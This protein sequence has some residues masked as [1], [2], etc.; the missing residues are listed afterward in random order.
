MRSLLRGAAKK[1]VYSRGVEWA[2]RRSFL[3]GVR[4]LT[5]HRFSPNE[6][7]TLEAHC[8]HF[9]K[10]YHPLALGDYVDALYGRKL[11]PANGLVVTV[12]D[13]YHDVLTVAAP[14]FERYRIPV[15]VHLV[16]GFVDRQCWLWWDVLTYA[17]SHSKRTEAIIELPD[18]PRATVALGAPERRRTLAAKCVVA[19]AGT[20]GATQEVWVADL[21][22]QL[23]VRV[24]AEP[25]EE[26]S[27][28]TWEQVRRMTAMG[29][30][31]GAHTVNHRILGA[32]ESREEKCLEI[33]D[34]RRRIEEQLQMPVEHF[35]YPN[36]GIGDFD[37]IDLALLKQAGYRSAVTTL[38]GIGDG[39]SE[40]PFQLPRIGID[41]TQGSGSLFRLN[42]AGLWRFRSG[43]GWRG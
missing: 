9:R 28:L 26:F 13:G 41:F 12:D 6:L 16:S 30:S 18:S 25:V 1:I 5:Y 31:F 42:L 3:G 39:R 15:M 14:V 2:I 8:R 43:T 40:D 38:K 27:A 20:D 17:F 22:K 37:R 34:S 33:V 29:F 23:D 36:G 4:V 32:L 24:P 10:Y 7:E 21:C 11:L 19:L 35:C